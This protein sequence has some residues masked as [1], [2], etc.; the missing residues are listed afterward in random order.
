L[1][2]RLDVLIKLWRAQMELKEQFAINQNLLIR[3]KTDLALG[4][5]VQKSFLP[6]YQMRT[7][8]FDLEA[9]FIPSGDLSGDY[10]DYRLITPE[11]LT[12]FLADVSGHG[13]A[14]ALLASRLKAFFD[15]NFRRAHR[16]RLFL[17]QLNRVLI[18]LGDHYHIATAVCV[19][20]D[21]MDTVVTYASSGHRSIYLLDTETGG[22]I[23]LP[24]TGPA[25]GMFDE[26]EITE[27][28][29]GFLPNRNRIVTYTDGLVEFKMDDGTWLTEEDFRDRFLLPGARD[30]LSKHVNDMLQGSQRLTGDGTWDD[31]VSLLA[32]D[33]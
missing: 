6:P 1:L 22:H 28:T 11:R 9:G 17:E 30:P 8:N 7:T 23:L 3:L 18:D 5:Q 26:F 29:H 27:E 32:V 2:T 12:I 4:Q 19:Y 33:F 16:P 24:A 15:E 21:V 25:L 10:F 13:V 14:S 31:D 20:V